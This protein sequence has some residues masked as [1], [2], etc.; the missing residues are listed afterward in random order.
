MS[1]PVPIENLSFGP[2]TVSDPALDFGVGENGF[3]IEG[4]VGI[5]VTGL[6]SGTITATADQ[7]GP[8]L[9]GV[10]NLDT[11]F[12]TPAQISAV[13]DV[14][15]DTLTVGA[16]WGSSVAGSLGSTP[17]ASRSAS[18]GMRS[19]SQARSRWGRRSLARC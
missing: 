17:A 6:G 5:A 3:F 14:A 13:Y 8:R 9:A 1:V 7:S 10:F 16:T 4:S 12:L 11:D 15:T 19:T 2:L 18:T